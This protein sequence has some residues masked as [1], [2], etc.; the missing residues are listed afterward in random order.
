MPTAAV[1]AGA[2]GKGYPCPPATL[3]ST[4][5]QGFLLKLPAMQQGCP[6]LPASTP[7]CCPAAAVN[8]VENKCHPMSRAA[9]RCTA[10]E[11]MPP[12][13]PGL[14]C[15]LTP[16]QLSRQQV[17]VLLRHLQAEN[18]PNRKTRLTL[19]APN[20]RQTSIC[21]TRNLAKGVWG[22]INSVNCLQGAV[23]CHVWQPMTATACPC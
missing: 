19:T 10:H 20:K 14:G 7:T 18:Q 15:S 11:Q 13:R 3:W 22:V 2:G 8:R 9:L 17:Q 6:P 23:L 5:L 16:W 21:M 4:A 12:A 1:A